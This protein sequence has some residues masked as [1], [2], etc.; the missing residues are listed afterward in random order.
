M[1][2][3]AGAF[4]PPNKKVHKNHIIVNIEE[5]LELIKTT[6]TELMLFFMVAA[7]CKHAA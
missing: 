3:S 4:L 7:F 6:L 2:F 5:S 1:L